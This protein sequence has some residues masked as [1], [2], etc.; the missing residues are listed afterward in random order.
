MLFIHYSLNVY[1]S[2]LVYWRLSNV[3]VVVSI[4][5]CVFTSPKLVGLIRVNSLLYTFGLSA[6]ILPS[7]IHIVHDE[8][9]LQIAWVGHG[10]RA[11]DVALFNLFASSSAHSGFEGR[12]HSPI[13]LANQALL[14][15]EGHSSTLWVLLWVMVIWIFKDVSRVHPGSSR[16]VYFARN[17]ALRDRLQ[18]HARVSIWFL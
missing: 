3:K 18:S 7:L 12:I 14:L 11:Q 15:L 8:Y 13:E 1:L 10:V 6:S 16:L 17:L 4:L 2:L 5:R 9:H